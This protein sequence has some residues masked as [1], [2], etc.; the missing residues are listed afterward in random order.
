MGIGPATGLDVLLDVGIV[1]IDLAPVAKRHD[2]VV[3]KFSS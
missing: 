2:D 3:E 1:S